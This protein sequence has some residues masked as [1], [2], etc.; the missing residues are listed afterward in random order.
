MNRE[1]KIELLKAISEGK[2]TAKALQ[3]GMVYFIVHDA[4]KSTFKISNFPQA[5]GE[6]EMNLEEFKAFKRKLEE[7][8]RELPKWSRNVILLFEET[9]QY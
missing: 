1:Q 5:K 3:E 6:E 7:Q 4:G 2:K 9:K 8:D